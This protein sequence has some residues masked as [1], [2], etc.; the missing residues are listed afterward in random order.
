MHFLQIAAR[1]VLHGHIPKDMILKGQ[2]RSI[3][4]HPEQIP[5]AF[6]QSV[7]PAKAGISFPFHWM[8]GE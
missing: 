2:E 6:S 4:L 7:I 3:L 1:I 5:S 8:M